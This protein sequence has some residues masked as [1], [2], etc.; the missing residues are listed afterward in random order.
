MSLT[1]ERAGYTYLSG[2]PFETDALHGVS[3]TIRDGEYLGIMGRTGCGKST[4]IQLLSGLLAPTEGRVLLDGAD[5]NAPGY[6]KAILRRSVG[7][8]F[9]YPESQLFESTVEKDVAF[10]LSSGGLSRTE[11]AERVTW[12][13]RT[14]G[15]DPE[16]MGE[17]SPLTLSGGQKRL[18]AIAGV[19]AAKPRILIFDEPIAGLDPLGRESF[20]ALTDRLCAQGVTI[21][22][23]SHN[24]DCLAEHA[25]RILVLQGGQ[26]ALEGTPEQVF[27]QVDR[28]DDLGIGVSQPRRIA[29]ML[30]AAGVPLP[31]QTVRYGELLE[32]LKRYRKGGMHP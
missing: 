1:L 22:L 23:V 26:I 27:A 20:L 31:D 5:I 15:L 19:L 28:M 4:M 11:T 14:V 24:A 7:V 29:A 6:E 32:G 3:L 10:G 9:Q 18:V 17:Q 25:A 12:A 2:T 8:V 16:S 21:V 30:Q 13:L